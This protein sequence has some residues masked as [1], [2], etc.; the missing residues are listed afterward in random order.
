M[1]HC[2]GIHVQL[3]QLPRL[4]II[5]SKPTYSGCDEY[6]LPV[7]PDATDFLES[8]SACYLLLMPPNLLV[9]E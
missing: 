2:I 9:C 5:Q 3:L 1:V 4:L 6:R 7:A 8:D